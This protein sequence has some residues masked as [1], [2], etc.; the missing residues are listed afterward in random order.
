MPIEQMDCVECSEIFMRSYYE[1]LSL[2]HCA[3]AY[4]RSSIGIIALVGGDAFPPTRATMPI[5]LL[6]DASNRSP[7]RSKQSICIRL[8]RCAAV[9]VGRTM[10]E[11][12]YKQRA[13]VYM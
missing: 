11:P 2:Q 4:P 8:R 6:G 13:A 3:Q 1:R 10:S 9:Q 5:E 12:K 7:R